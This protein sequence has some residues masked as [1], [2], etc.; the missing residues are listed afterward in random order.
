MK[1]NA[2]CVARKATCCATAEPTTSL[3]RGSPV[4]VQGDRLAFEP[5][6]AKRFAEVGPL[7][8]GVLKGVY[9]IGN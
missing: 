6:G 3:A 8:G 7:Q 1:A 5:I 9:K 2:P 4:S